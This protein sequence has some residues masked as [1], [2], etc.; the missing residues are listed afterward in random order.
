[1]FVTDRSP[2]PFAPLEHAELMRARLTTLPVAEMGGVVV[3]AAETVMTMPTDDPRRP[4]AQ[5]YLSRMLS[6]LDRHEEVVG[7][8]RA[9]S[10]GGRGSEHSVMLMA[11]YLSASTTMRQEYGGTDPFSAVDVA[12]GVHDAEVARLATEGMAAA[13]AVLTRELLG[14]A[15]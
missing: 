10:S 14:F 3:R 9:V 1:M 6:C 12:Q 4:Y 8:E 13:D 2:D 11:L 15:A 7:L 5:D